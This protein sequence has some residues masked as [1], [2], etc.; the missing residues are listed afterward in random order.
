MKN[1]YVAAIA[2]LLAIVSI[3]CSAKKSQNPMERI[4]ALIAAGDTVPESGFY[5]VFVISGAKPTPEMLDA[6]IFSTLDKASI[7]PM[8]D[9]ELCYAMHCNTDKFVAAQKKYINLLFPNADKFVVDGEPVTRAEF[10][11]IPVS[12]LMSVTGEE[13]G[14]KLVVE[15]RADAN[16]ENPVYNKLTEAERQ[17]FPEKIKAIPEKTDIVLDNFQTYPADT[18]IY[19]DG[20]LRSPGMLNALNPDKI[21]SITLFYIGDTPY[22]D[23]NARN[24]T[25]FLGDEVTRIP[26]SSLP[27]L[28]VSEIEKRAGE[29]LDRIVLERNTVYAFPAPSRQI[30]ENAAEASTMDAMRQLMEQM[31]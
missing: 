14:R 4:D 25:D 2:M 16:A 19:V 5:N 13:N 15:T 7:I 17:C 21:S 6:G 9:S 28:R 31:E 3:S 27:S 23:I 18:R 26:V 11:R 30:L 10:D 24:Y 29:R 22:L 8:D 1:H 20:I 12:L